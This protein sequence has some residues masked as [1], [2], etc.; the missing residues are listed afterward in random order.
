MVCVY[1]YVKKDGQANKLA[2][3]IARYIDKQFNDRKQTEG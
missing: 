3:Y 1:V 2:R